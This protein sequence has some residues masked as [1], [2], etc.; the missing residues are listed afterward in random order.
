MLTTLALSAV[1]AQPSFGSD[2]QL[3]ILP[4]SS[5]ALAVS[6]DGLTVAGGLGIAGNTGKAFVW[7]MGYEPV[8]FNG[9]VRSVSPDGKVAVGCVGVSSRAILFK[10]GKST[11][12]PIPE[13]FQQSF[14]QSTNGLQVFGYLQ[15]KDEGFRPAVYDIKEGIWTLVGDEQGIVWGGSRDGKTLFGRTLKSA[16]LLGDSGWDTVFDDQRGFQSM[17]NALSTN[18]KTIVGSTYSAAGTPAYAFVRQAKVGTKMIGDFNGGDDYSIA[19]SVT[20]DG[21]MVVG[22]GTK[23]SK[24][25][26]LTGGDTAF[27]WTADT[28]MLDLNEV[29]TMQYGLDLGDVRLTKVEMVTPNG[30]TMVGV[31]LRGKTPYGFRLTFK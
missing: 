10:D 4:F 19:T 29:L 26:R 11:V 15:S 12:L 27:V 1:L 5:Q 9:V 31:A 3:E 8:T 14:A 17:V 30:K 2:A 21:S 6:D 20:A 24:Q 28:G 18:G 25:T 23:F 13:Q 7:R 22:E 16:A